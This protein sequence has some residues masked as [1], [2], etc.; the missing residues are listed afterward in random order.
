[1]NSTTT[2]RSEGAGGLLELIPSNGSSCA[3]FD[4]R[5]HAAFQRMRRVSMDRRVFA[6]R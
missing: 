4:P 5:I 6:R 2:F 3:G 1:M